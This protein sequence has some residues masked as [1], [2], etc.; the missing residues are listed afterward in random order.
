MKNVYAE[1]ITIGD[2]ILYGQ[3]LD[4][5]TQWIGQ[6]LNEIGIKISRKISIS[7]HK[8]EIMQAIEEASGRASIVLITGGLGPTK[9][10]IT[11]QTLADYFGT[12]LERN[13]EALSHIKALFASRGREIT[14][15]NEKQADL[16]K[17]CT[18]I[19]NRM[20][21]APA[22]WFVRNE[23]IF[24]SMPGVP[25]EMK[26]IMEEEVL[27]RL[28][29]HFNLPLIIHQMIQTVGIGESWLSDHIAEWENNLPEQ[30]RLAYLP[31]FGKVKLRLTAVGAEAEKLHKLVEEQTQKVLPLIRKYVF[32]IGDVSLEEAVGQMLKAQQKTVALAE[33]CSGGYVAHSLTSIPG[34]SAYFQGGI[35]PYHN[36]LKENVLGVSHQTLLDH[37]AVSEQTVTEMAQQVRKLMQADYGLASSGVAGPGG[38]SD[39]KPVGTVWIA[40]A[41][42]EHTVTRKLMLTKDRMLNIKLTAVGLLNLLRKQFPHEN[43]LIHV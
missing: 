34:S 7:D 5:N 33:S 41:S 25:Y 30:L 21:T 13:E 38:G 2:E 1:V 12:S 6:R 37:G 3:T 24:V 27:P 4:T 40:V 35:V 9:D 15:T 16:P 20:G 36:E 8:G 32:A 19:S 43:Q 10:D 28:R 29:T 31:S 26:C 17:A 18:I 14:P 11:K 23:V 22:M 39:E 42:A